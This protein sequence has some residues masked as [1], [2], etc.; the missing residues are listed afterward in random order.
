MNSIQR[1][2][3]DE[4]GMSYVFVG[5][6]MMAFISASMLAIDVGMLM[7]ARSQAQ[8]AADA[9]ALA[10]ATALIYDNWD[11][12]SPTGPAVTNAVN[13]S[14]QNKVMSGNVS[15]GPADV[16]F[17]L[18]PAGE[19][20]RVKVTVYRNAAHG[21]PLNT[22]IAKY[23]GIATADIA[24]TATAEAADANAMTCVKPFTIPDKWTEKQT[25]PWDGNDTYDAYD[26]KGQPLANPD[27]YIPADQP[28]YTG[29]NQERERGQILTIRAAT[30]NNITVSFYF[31]LALGKPVLTGGAQY[32]WNIANCNTTSYYWGDLLTQ[33]PGAMNGPTIQGA[34][35]LITKDPSA[36]WDT[37]TN[38]VKGSAFG[39]SPRTFPIPLYDPIYYDSGKRNGRIADLKT[40]NWIGF[41]LDHIEGN[42]IVGRIIP[43]AGIRDRN[44]GPAPQGL[45]PKAIRLVQ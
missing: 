32:D 36:Y 34:E 19:P 41:F 5:F 40:A 24:A 12:R 43:I 2:R 42:G 27:I 22:M 1:L 20:N 44:G 25:P 13:A 26:N 15:V 11:D 31:S 45:N 21:N 16:E 17:P 30:G 14:L 7:T 29:Y 10:G 28:G 6:S 4:S 37:A 18:D 3:R 23:F 38:T 39:H 35:A 8:N 33:E 9:G